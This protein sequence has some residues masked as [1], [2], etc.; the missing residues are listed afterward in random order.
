V[1]PLKSYVFALPDG[2]HLGFP[3]ENDV[4]M[5]NSCQIRNPRS[6]INQKVYLH[7]ILSALIENLIFQDG[8][9]GHLGFGLLV[10]NA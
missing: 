9:G 2:G 8:A 1:F 5:S 7:M 10:K 6:R 3:A 4:V